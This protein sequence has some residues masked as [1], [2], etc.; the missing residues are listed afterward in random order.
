MLDD[1]LWWAM[2]NYNYNYMYNNNR[3]GSGKAHQGHINHVISG[4][5]K[6]VLYHVMLR[7]FILQIIYN[8]INLVMVNIGITC[9]YSILN[10]LSEFIVTII[11]I[12]AI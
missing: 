9:F 2:V 1:D 4:Q 5:S 3:L 7:E 8:L 10:R 11:T 6:I 12:D